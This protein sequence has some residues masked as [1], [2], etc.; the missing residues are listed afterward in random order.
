MTQCDSCFEHY[1]C[2]KKQ[3]HKGNHIWKTNEDGG[4]FEWHSPKYVIQLLKM[5][6]KDHE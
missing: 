6:W 1:Q 2:G 5:E 4:L 3:D